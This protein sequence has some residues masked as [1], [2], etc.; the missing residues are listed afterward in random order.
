MMATRRVS[1]VNYMQLQNLSQCAHK[2]EKTS[3]IRIETHKS[4][5]I[6]IVKSGFELDWVNKYNLFKLYRL[7]IKIVANYYKNEVDF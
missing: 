3:I 1:N 7:C 5:V 4:V 6:I 2:Q